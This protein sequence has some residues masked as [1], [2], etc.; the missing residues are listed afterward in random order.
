MLHEY[1]ELLYL[2]AVGVDPAVATAK[3]RVVTEAG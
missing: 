3:R 2:P 1:T